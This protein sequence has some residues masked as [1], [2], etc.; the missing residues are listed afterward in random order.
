MA[1]LKHKK[2]V[3]AVSCAFMVATLAACGGEKTEEKPGGQHAEGELQSLKVVVHAPITGPNASFGSSIELGAKLAIEENKEVFKALG[4]DLSVVSYDDE[5]KPELGVENAKKIVDDPSILALIGHFNSGVVRETLPIYNEAKLAIVSPGA[6]AV[7][8]TEVGNVFHRVNAHDDLQ[9][10]AAAKFAKENLKA[11]NVF[12]M[13]DDSYYAKGLTG[14][15][16]ETAQSI[17]LNI[18]GDYEI[19]ADSTDFAE[20]SEKILAANPDVVFFPGV[21]GQVGSFTKHVKQAGYEGVIFS[22]DSADA[23]GLLEAAGEEFIKDIYITALAGDLTLTNIGQDFKQ[24]IE[25][26]LGETP[27]NLSGFGYDATLVALDGIKK[28]AEGKDGKLPS[29][30]DVLSFISKTSNFQG[31]FATNVTFDEKGDNLNSDI[32][33]FNFSEGSYPGITVGVV[34]SSK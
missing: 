15:Y 30:E 6:S 2:L 4:Y 9:A 21:Y 24:K 31:T 16:K 18:V 5:S 7:D 32:F 23:P 29:R 12:V 26:E 3:T 13:T 25:K 28:A 8:L 27:G 14:I 17:G 20:A 22:A 33:I 1:F 19:A 10:E 34:S 11:S